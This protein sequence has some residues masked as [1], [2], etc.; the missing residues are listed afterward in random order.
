MKELKYHNPTTDF[1]TMVA[2]LSNFEGINKVIFELKELIQREVDICMIVNNVGIFRD[3]PYFKID[4]KQIVASTTC[5]FICQ[6]SINKELIPFLKQREKRS[7]IINMASASGVHF[8][9]YIGVYSST[10]HLSDVYSRTLAAENSKKIDILSV[11]PF[12]VRT[13]LMKM[14][15]GEFIITPK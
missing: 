11:R 6:Y 12:G 4:P 5:N 7:A 1:I 15:Q 10:K 2:D 13:P 8:C 9:P 3:G 14:M